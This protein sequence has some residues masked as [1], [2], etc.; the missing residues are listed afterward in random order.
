MNGLNAGQ[1]EAK[2]IYESGDYR[3]M[4]PGDFVVC[5]ITGARIPLDELRY[6][7]AER[8]EAYLSPAEVLKA[9]KLSL[10]KGD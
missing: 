7:S 2:L 8:Q 4:R 10:G 3:V 6:W 5:A 9:H 1:N